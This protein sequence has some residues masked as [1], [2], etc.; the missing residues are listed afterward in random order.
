MPEKS[1]LCDKKR[2]IVPQVPPV[3]KQAFQVALH[4][5]GGAKE[6]K[7]FYLQSTQNTQNY[8]VAE[9]PG[10][11]LVGGFVG[12]RRNPLAYE[13]PR[14]HS[15]PESTRHRGRCW[16]GILLWGVGQLPVTRTPVRE[17]AKNPTLSTSTGQRTTED[18][19]LAFQVS[20]MAASGDRRESIPTTSSRPSRRQSQTSSPLVRWGR[21]HRTLGAAIAAPFSPALSSS[22]SPTCKRQLSSTS[23]S[24]VLESTDEITSVPPGRRLLASDSSTTLRLDGAHA[25]PSP[26][27]CI[28]R[29]TPG[30][31]GAPELLG[32]SWLCNLNFA[33]LN[34]VEPPPH[35]RQ[36][37]WTLEELLVGPS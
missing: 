13:L 30:G 2:P 1:D 35:L 33:V 18:L 20:T 28:R 6:A 17:A 5:A 15:S 37:V 19:A 12:M 22:W 31:S 4:F 7:G 34:V 36:H 29:K 25:T 3:L 24:T 21:M 8:K 16:P 10:H 9:N 26:K 32:L 27:P 11:P 14:R 23:A